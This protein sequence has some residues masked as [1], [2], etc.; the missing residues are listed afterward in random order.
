MDTNIWSYS[1]EYATEPLDVEGFKVEAS[2]G[3]IGKVDEATYEVESSYIVVDTGPWIFGRKVVLPAG[4][5]E[6]I[7]LENEKVLVR[8]TKDQ[9]KDSPE[10]DE[11]TDY[12]SD[13]YRSQLGGGAAL[14]RGRGARRLPLHRWRRHLDPGAPDRREHRRHRSRIRSLQPRCGLC[15]GLPAPAPRLGVPRRGTRIHPAV[16]H[17]SSGLQFQSENV[18]ERCADLPPAVIWKGGDPWAQEASFDGTHPLGLQNANACETVVRSALDLPGQA[19]D[20]SRDR[21]DRKLG[22][23]GKE[24]LTSQHHHGT[25]LV[26]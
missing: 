25:A 6:R 1:R 23:G 11:T 13:E 4:V 7:D 15:R 10:L 17:W 9:I 14:G 2:D 3:D 21:N 24:I 16:G 22:Q 20:L 18:E 5:I 12:R 19:S 8:L 26:R